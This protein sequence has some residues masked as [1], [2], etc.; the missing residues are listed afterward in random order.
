[1]KYRA[2]VFDF[3]GTLY[4]DT[5]YHNTAWDLFL[6]NH[7]LWL[8]DEEKAQKIHGKSNDDILKTLFDGKL[9][10]H[11]IH[12][13]GN[14]KELIYHGIALKE[15]IE[16]APGAIDFMKFLKETNIDFSIATSSTWINIE[17]YL[18]HMDLAKWVDPEKIIYENGNFR[19]KPNP[20]I[21]LLAMEKLNALPEEVLVFE[22]SPTGIM[23]AENAGAG[24]IIVVNSTGR[25]HSHLPYK[26]IHHFD[27]VDRNIFLKH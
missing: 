15:K 23:A 20:D 24:E 21:F 17:F 25:N 19:S 8:T 11:E 13:M 26:V 7:N 2:V 4:W 5:V 9:N 22:D 6:K 3:N 16:F 1:M 12:Q 27:E 18:K 10:L 14:E